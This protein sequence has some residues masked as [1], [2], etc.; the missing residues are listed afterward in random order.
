[1]EN[2]ENIEKFTVSIKEI[3]SNTINSLPKEISAIIFIAIG[4][5]IAFYI[6]KF[7]R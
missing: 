5:V 4:L 3:I 7:L 6:Y 2:I 1:M